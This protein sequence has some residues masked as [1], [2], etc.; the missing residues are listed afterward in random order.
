MSIRISQP[1]Q[2]LGGL[3]FANGSRAD[4]VNLHRH[5][6]RQKLPATY[7]VV[8][9]A[10]LTSPSGRR[11]TV[12]VGV[13][14]WPV[15]MVTARNRHFRIRCYGKALRFANANVRTLSR[16]IVHPQF[17]AAGLA[18]QIVR[19]LVDRSP[20]R[21]VE[22]S[23]TMGAYAGFLT[24]CGFEQIA[25]EPGE[26]SYFLFDRNSRRRASRRSANR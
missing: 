17:R 1:F 7:C 11:R 3:R 22:C 25:T 26:P 10:R 23:T 15:P 13:L 5:H 6:Y 24:R 20:T 16:V 12:A 14:S 21:Y 19:Q 18:Q 8:R 2:L 4:V 9:T